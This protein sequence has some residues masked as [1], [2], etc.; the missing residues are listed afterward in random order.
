LQVNERLDG[1]VAGRPVLLKAHCRLGSERTHFASG[2]EGEVLSCQLRRTATLM[3][4]P[5]G[6]HI[7]R[8]L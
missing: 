7:R 8:I 2:T 3:M 5:P 4:A 1:F 6:L